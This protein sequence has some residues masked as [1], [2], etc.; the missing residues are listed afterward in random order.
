[1]GVRSWVAN[2]RPTPLG[3]LFLVLPAFVGSYGIKFATRLIIL[4]IFVVSLDFLLGLGF[5]EAFRIFANLVSAG[6]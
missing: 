5:K 2:W 4:S 6:K 3:A 1:M